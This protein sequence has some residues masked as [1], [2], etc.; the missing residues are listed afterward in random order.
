VEKNK[1]PFPFKKGQRVRRKGSIDMSY[2]I[3]WSNGSAQIGKDDSR[4]FGG[5]II[6]EDRV[7][8]R[9]KINNKWHV[10]MDYIDELQLC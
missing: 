9:W 2:G 4:M 8:V 1:K 5:P 10:C 6:L 7:F 3:V